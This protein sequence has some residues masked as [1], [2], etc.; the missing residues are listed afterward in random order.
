MIFED[1]PAR[2]RSGVLDA[3]ALL[4]TC[5]LS[6]LLTATNGLAQD[7]PPSAGD[8][9]ALRADVEASTELSEEQRQELSEQL[10]SAEQSMAAAEEFAQELEELQEKLAQSDALIA[11]YTRRAEDIERAPAKIRNRLGANPGLADIE[12]EI[13]VVEGQRKDWSQERTE[14]LDALANLAQSDA[15]LRERLALLDDDMPDAP[16]NDRAEDEELGDRVGRTVLAARTHAQEVERTLIQTQLRG[17]SDINAIRTANIRWLDAAISEADKLLLELRAA[18]VASRANVGDQ[19][20]AEIRRIVNGLSDGREEIQSLAAGNR[21]LVDEF[22]VLNRQIDQA[23]EDVARI[24]T[25]NE[26]IEQDSQLTIRRLE[27]TGLEAELG[28]VMLSRLASLPSTSSILADNRTLS[29]SIAEV[30]SSAIDTEQELRSLSDRDSYLDALPG[31]LEE[32]TEREQNAVERLLELRRTLLSENL[33]AQNT[34]LRILV[35]E[36]QASE[37]LAEATNAYRTLL[38]GNLLWVRNY[39]YARP[40]SLERQLKSSLELPPPAEVLSSW[41]VLLQTSPFV[42]GVFILLLAGVRH[43]AARSTLETILGSPIRPRDESAALI[44][45]TLTLTIIACLFLPLIIGLGGYGLAI[46]A[47]GNAA[48]GSLGKA[49]MAAAMVYFFLNTLRQMASRFGVGRRLLKW[50]SPRAD[51]V[52]NDSNWFG[53]T[54]T[55]AAAVQVYG[56][57]LTPTESG[58][59]L[60]AA[61]SLVMAASLFLLARHMLRSEL[62]SSDW[63]V[64]NALR[65]GL[66]LSF[67][68]AVMHI[69]GQLFAAHLYLRALILSIAAI[70]A[71]LLVANILQRILV[72]YRMGL[73]RKTREEQRAKQEDDENNE[74]EDDSALEAV[75]SLSAAYTQLL[76]MFRLLALGG[77]L[78]LIWS[79]ALPALSIF[80]GVTLWQTVDPTLPAGELRDITLSVLLFAAIAIVVTVLLTKHVPPLLNVL[81]MEWTAVSPGGRYAAGMLLQYLIIGVGLS[82]TLAMLGFQWSK[83]Q[84]LVA[85]LGV[86]IGFGLQEIVANFISGLI[87]LFERPIRVGDIINAGGHDGTVVNINPRATVIETFEGK[88]VMIPNKEL[89]TNIVTNWSLSSSKLRIVVPVGIAYGSDVEDA[90]ARLL[91]IARADAEILKDPEPF[92]TFED[93]GDNAL[94]LWLRCYALKDYLLIATRLRRAIYRDFNDA[95]IG[96]AFPQ[97]DVHLDASDPLPIRILR[98]DDEAE[99]QP[100]PKESQPE[101][102]KDV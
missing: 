54:F 15:T 59:A 83:V 10:R 70:V 20:R 2:C 23:R 93:F 51:F 5:I 46:L 56:R 69:S 79:P 58:G 97:R 37:E 63:I 6:L 32:M 31:S 18:A 49:L 85:A 91:R 45:K 60:G 29:E 30:S 75:S 68:I 25:Q 38:T 16:G 11:S 65:A 8:L 94:V 62:F 61:S 39:S 90:I 22:Q 80:D 13:A 72:L 17:G 35:D 47:Q 14:A 4:R 92:V 33:E 82:S 98:E 77:L 12:G 55:V 52:I 81:L 76:I 36:N 84:W 21:T 27:V 34:L 24:R 26:S 101:P 95:G 99:S 78:W 7:D 9:E 64:R 87:V 3:A 48:L 53:P 73:E 67:A 66:I 41:P 88:E 57:F 100:E 86:G 50:N 71:T 28:D 19:R 1:R 74:A 40:A 44:A 43:R 102:K 89:I 42:L 96:I